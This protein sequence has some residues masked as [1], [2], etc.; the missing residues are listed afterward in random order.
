MD[1]VIYNVKH[2]ENKMKKILLIS[3][4]LGVDATRYL[5]GI[6]RKANE[7]VLTA[8]LYIGG[9][10]LAL[11]YENMLSEENAYQLYLNGV[12]T[13]FKIS[14]KEALLACDWDIVTFQQASTKSGDFATYEPY[15]SELSSYVKKFVPQ[16][17]QYIHAI[18]PWSDTRLSN[19]TLPY[20]TF[21]E[22][23][24]RDNEAYM[25]AARAINADGYI[26]ATIAMEKLYKKIGDGAY[27]D[28]AHASYGV[29]RYMLGLLWY[30]V[31]FDKNVCGIGYR[32]FDVEMSDEEIE[33]A[34]RCTS[35]TLAEFTYEKA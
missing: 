26:P 31:L 6:C 20:A 4:S 29:G 25:L 5:Y 15:L 9:C 21:E 8:C 27:R 23:A 24:K 1:N 3:N 33:I 14:I 12:E 16:A 7:N 32:D 22:M 28:G 2:G 30:G 35:E 13:P 34:E 18:W 11:H 19:G 10:S 17:K